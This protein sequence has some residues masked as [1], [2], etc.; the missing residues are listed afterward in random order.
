MRLPSFTQVMGPSG[1][2]SKREGRSCR[3]LKE[4][5]SEK[6]RRTFRPLLRDV[7]YSL[8]NPQRR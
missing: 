7:R 2:V 6:G 3:S 8:P 1:P 4:A 5:S